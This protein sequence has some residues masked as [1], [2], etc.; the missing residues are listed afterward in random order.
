M[1]FSQNRDLG[2][3]VLRVGIGFMFVLH[4]LSKLLGGSGTWES[5]GQKG[6]PFLPEGFLVLIFGLAAAVAEFGGGILLCLGLFH[7]YVCAVLGLTMA[8]AFTTKLEAI[9]GPLDFA[10]AAGWPLELLIVFVA[11]FLTGPGRYVVSKKPGF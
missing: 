8:V 5:I 2:L 3:L 10:S 9:T 1:K 7:R 11:L 4:G 6:L